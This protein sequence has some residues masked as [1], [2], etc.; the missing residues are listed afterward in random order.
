MGLRQNGKYNN[1]EIGKTPQQEGE[2]KLMELAEQ[3]KCAEGIDYIDRQRDPGAH[4]YECCVDPHANI[5]QQNMIAC[6]TRTIGHGKILQWLNLRQ[7]S[8]RLEC[9]AMA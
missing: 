3:D 9:D 7:S 6:Q 5:L 2:E 1:G 4:G 8:R